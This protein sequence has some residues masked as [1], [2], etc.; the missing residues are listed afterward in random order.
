MYMHV[1]VMCVTVL[2][3]YMHVR[4]GCAWCLQRSEEELDPPGVE[5]QCDLPN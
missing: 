2:P 5:L 1:N 4:Y 3:E